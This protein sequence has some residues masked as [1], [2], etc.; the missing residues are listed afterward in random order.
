MKRKML[1]INMSQPCWSISSSLFRGDLPFW[2]TECSEMDLWTPKTRKGQSVWFLSRSLQRCYSYLHVFRVNRFDMGGDWQEASTWSCWWC[3]ML[4]WLA[5]HMSS[6]VSISLSR[7]KVSLRPC[8]LVIK[9]WWE[10]KNGSSSNLF[11]PAITRCQDSQY[12]PALFMRC[13]W[14]PKP[15]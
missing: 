5:D 15:G 3:N 8:L 4:L 14:S 2:Q 1:V 11:W 9:K 13:E 7:M 12:I 6:S 10:N